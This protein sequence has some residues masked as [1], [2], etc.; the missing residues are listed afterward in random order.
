MTSGTGQARTCTDLPEPLSQPEGGSQRTRWKAA[1]ELPHFHPER[2]R[3]EERTTKSP[4]SH[5]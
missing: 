2:S 5:P 4:S 3:E 1:Q